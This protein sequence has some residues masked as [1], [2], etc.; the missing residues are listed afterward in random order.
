[1]GYIGFGALFTLILCT[2]FLTFGHICQKFFKDSS[3]QL[4]ILIPEDMNYQQ[5]FDDLMKKYTQSYELER[6]KT[7]NLG[8]LFELTYK[9]NVD[10][11]YNEKEFIDELRCRNGNLN[12]SI[13]KTEQKTQQL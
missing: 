12:I 10:D 4:K 11:T 2:A 3:K 7:T 6:V 5:V 8:S 9:I 13:S 1:M